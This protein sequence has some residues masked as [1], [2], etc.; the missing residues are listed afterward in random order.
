MPITGH[1]TLGMDVADIWS[2]FLDCN[3]QPNQHYILQERQRLLLPQMRKSPDFFKD[4]IQVFSR[5]AKG[6]KLT[7]NS[8]SEN[9]GFKRMTNVMA[10]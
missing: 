1:I 2:K 10:A 4:C 5:K 7:F 9:A 3:Q 8:A 6:F